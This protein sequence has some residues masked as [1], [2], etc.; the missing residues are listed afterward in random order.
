MSASFRPKGLETWIYVLDENSLP[1]LAHTAEKLKELVSGVQEWSLHDIADVIRQDPIMMV[2]LFRETQRVFKER[3]Q[4]T[5]TDINHC[6][7]LLG[8]D[9]ILAL[10]CQFQPMKGDVTDGN[11][12]AYQSAIVQSFHAAEQLLAWHQVRPQ[13]AVDKNYLAAQLMGV[14]SWCLW[15]HA[16]REM[17]I[18]DL[19]VK[20]QRIPRAE[21]ERAVLGCTTQEIVRALAERWNFPDIIINALDTE[22]LPSAHFL[23]GVAHQGY[24][25]KEP[26]IP[27]KDE[28]GQIVK[29]PSFIVALAHWLANEAG[30]D[31]YSR[32]TRR[33]LA[34]LAAYLEVDLHSARLVAQR[35]ALKLSRQF[36]FPAVQMPAARLLL[37]PQPHLRRYVSATRL[38]NVVDALARGESV[39]EMLFTEANETPAVFGGLVQGAAKQSQSV[40]NA[41]EQVAEGIMGFVSK[42]KYREFKQHLA[43]LSNQR[44]PFAAEQDVLRLSLDVLFAATRLRRVALFLFDPARDVLNGY[45]ALGCEDYPEITEAVIKLSP[46]NIFTQLIQK[47]QGFWVHPERKAEVTASISGVFKP[48]DQADEFLAMSVFNHCRPVAVLYADRVTQQQDGLS[49]IDFKIT[50]ALTDAIGKYLARMGKAT[51][52]S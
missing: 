36:E 1:V 5:L 33:V 39:P 38:G 20:Q 8:Q 17:K 23:A 52:N 2:Y 41:E 11:E 12:I 51:G 21:A 34:I 25:K 42:E 50:Q 32:Q 43:L 46:P 6:V 22:H 31:W 49:E 7:S 26:R 28:R 18:I 9:R 47:A 16:R 13:A 44:V 35:A 15:Y 27:N 29:T 4:G 40:P 19:L 24:S 45:Y 37:P 14:P 30:I 48:L 10:V 3:V